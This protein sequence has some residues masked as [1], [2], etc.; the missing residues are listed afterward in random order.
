MDDV[1]ASYDAYAVCLAL[2]KRCQEVA[3]VRV[4]KLDL[5]LFLR[6]R[7]MVHGEPL[8]LD[9][10]EGVDLLLRFRTRL[11]YGGRLSE[12]LQKLEEVLVRICC[13]IELNRA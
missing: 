2:W 4:D 7:S 3:V 6:I 13:F 1:V 12:F 8:Q 10:V 5:V 11:L 9:V